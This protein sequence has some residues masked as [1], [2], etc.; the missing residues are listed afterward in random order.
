MLKLTSQTPIQVTGFTEMTSI[1]VNVSI[2]LVTAAPDNALSIQTLLGL[3]DEAL[4]QAKDL[5][6]N[7]IVISEPV[8]HP[9]INA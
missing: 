8:H 6:G 9:T 3:A 7:C 2:G 1:H 4:Y 5:G